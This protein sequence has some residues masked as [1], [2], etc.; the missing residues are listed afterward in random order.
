M[1][2]ILVLL[3]MLAGG[4]GLL[5]LSQATLGVGIICG[6][7]LLAILARMAQAAHQHRELIRKLESASVVPQPNA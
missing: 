2:G 7:C 4:G 1:D 6:G 3:S 5:L